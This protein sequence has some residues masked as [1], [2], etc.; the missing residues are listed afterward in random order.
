MVLTRLSSAQLFASK[1]TH[2]HVSLLRTHR[3]TVSRFAYG[4][5][6]CDV[7]RPR[8]YNQFKLKLFKEKERKKEK[9]LSRDPLWRNCK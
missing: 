6:R 1:H 8:H 3:T 2:T 9:N 7:G 4:K 5:H